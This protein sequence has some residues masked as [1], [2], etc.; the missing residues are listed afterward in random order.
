MRAKFIVG[1]TF[2][3]TQSSHEGSTLQD[4]LPSV[5]ASHSAGCASTQPQ[6]FRD[7]RLSAY[8]AVLAEIEAASE[9][10]V[11]LSPETEA[12][13]TKELVGR[14]KKMFR[15]PGLRPGLKA[16]YLRQTVP[17]IVLFRDLYGGGGFYI[18]TNQKGE[19][20]M[21]GVAPTIGRIPWSPMPTEG[22]PPVQQPSYDNSNA[23]IVLGMLEDPLG[24]FHMPPP[25][26]TKGSEG[27]LDGFLAREGS[28]SFSDSAGQFLRLD[29]VAVTAGENETQIQRAAVDNCLTLIRTVDP[30][31]EIAESQVV[32][33]DFERKGL[34]VTVPF[35]YGGNKVVRAGLATIHN[36]TVYILWIQKPQPRGNDMRQKN[37]MRREL[38]K[39]MNAIYFTP[40][41][42]WTPFYYTPTS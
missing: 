4:R 5:A 39:R 16:A 17:G 25:V 12:A 41:K 34:F 23:K 38:R 42:E 31:A 19:L 14:W 13:V 37:D 20:F 10:P 3:G 32:N 40:S 9:L 35:D 15:D 26:P 33:I 36:E 27:I 11:Q 1:S 21:T 28:L 6:G 8:P 29:V 30:S 22:V 7:N 18:G 2:E 24:R